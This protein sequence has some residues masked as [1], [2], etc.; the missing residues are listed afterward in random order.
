MFLE[1]IEMDAV[2]RVEVKPL[3][4][5]MPASRIK[6]LFTMLRRHYFVGYGVFVRGG[7][8]DSAVLSPTRIICVRL[9]VEGVLRT[10]LLS[11][12]WVF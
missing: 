2:M 9:T 5:A 4:I 12:L 3:R 6:A 11:L 10:S 1:Q 8:L 7:I